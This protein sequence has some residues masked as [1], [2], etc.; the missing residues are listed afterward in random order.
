MCFN[1]FP[2]LSS[3]APFALLLVQESVPV[4]PVIGRWLREANDGLGP[5]LFAA[6]P[7]KVEETICIKGLPAR[8]KFNLGATLGRIE[9]PWTLL[10]EMEPG[11]VSDLVHTSFVLNP[12]L[13]AVLINFNIADVTSLLAGILPNKIKSKDKDKD[14][15]P[16]GRAHEDVVY[17]VG[18]DA[19]NAVVFASKKPS[20]SETTRCAF[21]SAP[22]GYKERVLPSAKMDTFPVHRLPT[23]SGLAFVDQVEG[24]TTP[25]HMSGKV[26]ALPG[27]CP[28]PWVRSGD[29]ST[30]GVLCSEFAIHE[31]PKKLDAME[32]LLWRRVVPLDKLDKLVVA[33]DIRPCETW[34][35]VFNDDVPGVH[36]VRT[37]AIEA[38]TP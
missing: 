25:S 15:A 18:E 33:F 34:N 21:G 26:V 2:F 37:P 23:A 35:S 6:A 17:W 30:V 10:G 4:P 28:L 13:R 29:P 31:D 16:T 36:G 7:T 9:A 12:T 3:V 19:N 1:P 22:I 11:L 24:I 8:V 27:Q 38:C 5:R 20:P 32:H 14:K